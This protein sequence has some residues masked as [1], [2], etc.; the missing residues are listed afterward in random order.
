[1]QPLPDES[2][3]KRCGQIKLYRHSEQIF[4]T[5]L[6][7]AHRVGMFNGEFLNFIASTLITVLHA[8]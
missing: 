8:K 2:R 4:S 6:Q 5:C 7:K 1:M 3:S